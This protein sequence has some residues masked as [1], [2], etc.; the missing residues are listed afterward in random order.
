MMKVIFCFHRIQAYEKSSATSCN[1]RNLKKSQK[2][3]FL[4]TNKNYFVMVDVMY[5]RSLNRQSGEVVPLP[6][7]GN[8]SLKIRNYRHT[9]IALLYRPYGRSQQ[10]PL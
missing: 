4:C 3:R 8:F 6:V 1:L 2:T 7:L 5:S 10:Y 9:F